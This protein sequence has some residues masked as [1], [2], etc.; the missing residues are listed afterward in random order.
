MATCFLPLLRHADCL[1]AH[2][3]VMRTGRIVN[4]DDVTSIFCTL[5]PTAQPLLFTVTL[6]KIEEYV[7]LGHL[8][9]HTYCNM[10]TTTTCTCTC[11]F[12]YYMYIII[13]CWFSIVLQL[14]ILCLLL[15][16]ICVCAPHIQS[17]LNGYEV[18]LGMKLFM[19]VLCLSLPL[20]E[21]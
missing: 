13:M 18:Y 11:G 9:F 4:R 7:Y 19:E 20:D 3:W 1:Q 16:Y 10:Q 21:V 6:K 15:N 14:L 17:E 12:C 5:H 8:A 2:Y